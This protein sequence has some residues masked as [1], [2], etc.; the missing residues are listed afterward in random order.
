MMF[1]IKMMVDAKVFERK[2]HDLDELLIEVL[3]WR[4]IV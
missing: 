2:V 3:N 4:K 1:L